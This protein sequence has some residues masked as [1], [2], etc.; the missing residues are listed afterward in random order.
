MPKTSRDMKKDCGEPGC[1]NDERVG[2]IS[3]MALNGNAAAV[4]SCLLLR[5]E[6]T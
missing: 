3:A 1:Q 2:L 6:R 5:E 4:T